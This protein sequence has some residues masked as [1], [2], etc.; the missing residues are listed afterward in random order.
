MNNTNLKILFAGGGSGGHIY[1]LIAVIEE[2]KK[3]AAAN[4]LSLELSYMGP[5]DEFNNLLLGVGDLK[6]IPIFGAKVRRYFSFANLLDGP[7]F[8]ISIFQAILKTFWLMPDVT[9]SKGG[10][11]GFPVVFASWF[12]RIPV[13]I[14]ESDAIPGVTNLLSAKFSK[15][16]AVSFEKASQYFDQQKTAWVGSP[17]R[18]DLDEFRMDQNSAKE[19]LQFNPEEPLLLILGGSQGSTRLNEFLIT[20]LADLIK[21]TQILHQAGS[22]N[23]NEAKKLSR[24]AL[25]ETTLQEEIKHRYQIVPFL[26]NDLK[27]ALT[28][29][30]LIVSRA[31]SGTI[32]E[33]AAFG[34]PAILIPLQESANDHQK[35][36]AFE[37][38]KNGGGVVIE[39]EN[40]L[41][42]I[43]L[44]QIQTL[45]K[46]KNSLSRMA[47]ASKRF[48][49]TGAAKSIAEEIL[50]LSQ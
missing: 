10:T 27:Y 15:R 34:K 40:L 14:H 43:F 11:G 5:K 44:N 30:D 3:I 32:F 26:E 31:G 25:S 24:A 4:N 50:K 39:E 1:P 16:V 33:I 35:M 8:V 6:I 21:D 46:D 29:A 19:Q 7:K 2:I 36:N 12:F 49:K 20:N 28:A 23:F 38:T 18:S 45:L 48:Y 22:A 41:P 9:F 47:I 42:H 17:I 13:I 37:F